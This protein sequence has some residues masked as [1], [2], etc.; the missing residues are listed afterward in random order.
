MNVLLI[1][2]DNKLA[3]TYASALTNAGHNVQHAMHAQD[4]VHA[5]DAVTPDVVLLELQLAGHSGVEFLYE[6]R[7]YP[8]WQTVPVILLTVTPPAAIKLTKDK[9]IELGIA[10]CL[11]KP[12]TNLNRLVDVVSG[13]L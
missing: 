2:P 10:D 3:K 9:Q 1:E 6:F 11:Y 5:A 13:V 12:S 7:S 4:A 8:E